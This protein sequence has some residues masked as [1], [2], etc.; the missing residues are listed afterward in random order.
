MGP[1]APP[2]WSLP[3]IFRLELIGKAR[4]FPLNPQEVK[5]FCKGVNSNQ[6]FPH[7]GVTPST[8]QLQATGPEGEVIAHKTR[9]E[10][11][12]FEEYVLFPPVGL[13]RSRVLLDF[14]FH[15]SRGA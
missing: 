13:K 1:P 12:P 6:G 3:L 5:H 11:R 10:T 8:P 7:P 2:G 14:Y 9:F 15:F 4:R